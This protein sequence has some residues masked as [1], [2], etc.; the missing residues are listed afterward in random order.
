MLPSAILLF[1]ILAISVGCTKDNNSDLLGRWEWEMA[2]VNQNIGYYNNVVQYY[3]FR[4]GGK[5]VYGQSYP[6]YEYATYQRTFT[7]TRS[8]N[9]IYLSDSISGSKTATL[10]DSYL[11]I[12]KHFHRVE[13]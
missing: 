3:E 11:D 8:G 1:V 2:I 5:G 6:T 13:W 7:W 9:T 10:F 12:G 4:E